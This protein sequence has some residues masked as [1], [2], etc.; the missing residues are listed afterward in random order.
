VETADGRQ[1]RLLVASSPDAPTGPVFIHTA[2]TGIASVR[3]LVGPWSVN[4]DRTVLLAP[5]TDMPYVAHSD[6][7]EAVP[8]PS[9]ASCLGLRRR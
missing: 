8:V 5:L 2:V 9:L 4:E 7:Q 3:K 6:F 1:T